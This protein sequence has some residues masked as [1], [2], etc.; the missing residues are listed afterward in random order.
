[1]DNRS[2][3]SGCGIVYCRTRDS[4]EQ[5]TVELTKKGVLCKPYHAGLKV[6]NKCGI[7]VSKGVV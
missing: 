6:G 1:M 5:G 3:T 2:K 4:T 7:F